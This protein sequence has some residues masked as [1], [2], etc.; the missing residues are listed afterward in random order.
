MSAPGSVQIVE[1]RLRV[2]LQM[3]LLVDARQ[4]VGQMVMAIV[5]NYHI[6]SSA[7]NQPIMSMKGNDAVS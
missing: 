7:A 6:W 3:P 5:T 2:R 4:R 1:V